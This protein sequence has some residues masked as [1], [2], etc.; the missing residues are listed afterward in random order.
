V[1]NHVDPRFL[2]F[3]QLGFLVRGSPYFIVL[4]SFKYDTHFY[5][6]HWYFTMGDSDLI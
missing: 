4:A 2:Q 6:D 5:R 1:W 3:Q